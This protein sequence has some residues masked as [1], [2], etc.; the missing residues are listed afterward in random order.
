M[1]TRATRRLADGL[2]WFGIG[3]GLA[4]VVAPG[5]LARAIGV[6]SLGLVRAFGVREVAAGVGILGGRHKRAGVWARIAGDA[7][8]AAVLGAALLRPTNTKR[9]NVILAIAAVSP[10]IALDLL[11]GWKLG[12]A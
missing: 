2:G 7:L 10:V 9:G 6:R 1:N 12:V 4:E 11:C 5:P 3:L 8:D